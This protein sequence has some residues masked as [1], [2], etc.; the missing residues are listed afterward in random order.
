MNSRTLGMP[1]LVPNLRNERLPKDF[2][3]PR[4]VPNYTADQSPEP[5]IESY[6]MAMEMLDFSDAACAKYFTMMLD[7]PTR[8]WLK[9]L[10]TNSIRSLAELKARFIQNLKDTC[11]QPMSI[12]DLDSCVQGESESTTNRVRWI[13]AVIHL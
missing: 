9:G 11:K 10:P 12:L 6:E 4:K 3:G 1:C 2:K 5:W 8:T 13:S 7:G